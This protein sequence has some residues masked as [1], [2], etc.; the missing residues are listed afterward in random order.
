M[1]QGC[2]YRAVKSCQASD[3]ILNEAEQIVVTVI[4]N[5]LEGTFH[6]EQLT[7][8]LRKFRDLAWAEGI[9]LGDMTDLDLYISVVRTVAGCTN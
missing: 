6:A 4:N 9:S 7:Q 3:R 1:N 8:L 2:V 5:T